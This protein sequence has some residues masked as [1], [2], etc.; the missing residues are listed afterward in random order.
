M[1]PLRIVY[2]DN[3]RE[4]PD[5]AFLPSSMQKPLGAVHGCMVLLLC[6]SVWRCLETGGGCGLHSIGTPFFSH[7]IY[8]ACD[9]VLIFTT[10]CSDASLG[11]VVGD[12]L[13]EDLVNSR[14]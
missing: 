14:S 1:Q 2:G 3:G 5:L 9:Y 11:T 8:L 12:F 10:S 13:C 4:P 6:G 7:I